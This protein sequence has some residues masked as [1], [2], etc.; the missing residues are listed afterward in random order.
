MSL[1]RFNASLEEFRCQL[2]RKVISHRATE[3][4]AP[5][6]PVGARIGRFVDTTERPSQR[7]HYPL[8]RTGH[9][10]EPEHRKRFC[11]SQRCPVACTCHRLNERASSSYP[12]YQSGLSIFYVLLVPTLLTTI[13]FWQCHTLVPTLQISS[14]PL[15]VDFPECLRT[16][17]VSC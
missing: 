7:P 12:A 4:Y 11:K 14:I 2:T 13:A 8:K 6:L 5:P 15:L 1:Q 3:R 17:V 9:V 10:S 16:L